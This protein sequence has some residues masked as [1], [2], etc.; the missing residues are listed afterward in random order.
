MSGVVSIT[1][2][3]RTVN[4][5]AL[6]SEG[7]YTQITIAQVQMD[8]ESPLTSVRLVA[9]DDSSAA[10]VSSEN[11]AALTFA[12]NVG[13]ANTYNVILTNQNVGVVVTSTTY[14]LEATTSGTYAPAPHATRISIGSGGGLAVSVRGYNHPEVSTDAMVLDSAT[15][16]VDGVTRVLYPS[17]SAQRKDTNTGITDA[18]RNVLEI[19]VTQGVPFLAGEL[20][21]DAQYIVSVSESTA[22][23]KI[24]A[25]DEPGDLVPPTFSSTAV[26]TYTTRIATLPSVTAGDNDATT[27]TL[28]IL[29]TDRNGDTVARS[30]TVYHLADPTVEVSPV[31]TTLVNSVYTYQSTGTNVTAFTGLVTNRGSSFGSP[32]FSLA[33]NTNFVIT[34]GTSMAI[35]ST[36]ATSD[37]SMLTLAVSGNF[38]AIENDVVFA[39][40][41]I[42]GLLGADTSAIRVWHYDAFEATLSDGA[43][44][45]TTGATVIKYKSVLDTAGTP[46][47]IAS[48]TATGGVGATVVTISGTNAG[49]FAV[50]GSY[51]N[52]ANANSSTDAATSRSITVT[53]TREFSSTSF[54]LTVYF[55]NDPTLVATASTNTGTVKLQD[56]TVN[57]PVYVFVYNANSSTTLFSDIKTAR[58]ATFAGTVTLTAG[59]GLAY[60]SSTLSVNAAAS[61]SSTVPKRVTISGNTSIVE[62]GVTFTTATGVAVDDGGSTTTRASLS[63]YYVDPVTV[64]WY[65]DAGFTSSAGITF[66]GNFATGSVPAPITAFPGT[67]LSSGATVQNVGFYASKRAESTTRLVASGRTLAWAKIVGGV[68]TYNAE[69]FTWFV[70]NVSDASMNSALAAIRAYTS[71]G[72]LVANADVLGD[73]ST[74]AYFIA[75]WYIPNATAGTRTQRALSSSITDA[76][77]GATAQQHVI[78]LAFLSDPSITLSYVPPDDAT[79]GNGYART[80]NDIPFVNLALTNALVSDVTG[81]AGESLALT[82]ADPVVFEIT[83]PLNDSST[84][85]VISFSS[86]VAANTSLTH[87]LYFQSSETTPYL[88]YTENGVIFNAAST[89]S[90]SGYVYLAG[91]GG[92]STPTLT[93]SLSATSV[94]TSALGI[95]YVNIAWNN[96]GTGNK[97]VYVKSSNSSYITF[98]TGATASFTF[99]AGT[100]GS[101]NLLFVAGASSVPTNTSPASAN[102]TITYGFVSPPTT[103]FTSNVITLYA[104]L[105]AASQGVSLGTNSNVVSLQYA[106]V[107]GASTISPITSSDIVFPATGAAA[108]YVSGANVYWSG[109]NGSETLSSLA[110]TNGLTFGAS[111]Q[112]VVITAVSSQVP[113]LSSTTTLSIEDTVGGAGSTASTTFQLASWKPQR[114]IFNGGSALLSVSVGP[115]DVSTT[116]TGGHGALISGS[117]VGGRGAI[118]FHMALLGDDGAETGVNLAGSDFTVSVQSAAGLDNGSGANSAGTVRVTYAGTAAE[119]AGRSYALHVGW[120]SAVEAA[121]AASLANASNIVGW[122]A[123]AA[124]AT[125]LKGAVRVI[126]ATPLSGY[127]FSGGVLTADAN[128][129]LSVD[130]ELLVLNDRV[131]VIGQTVAA[132]NGIYFVSTAGSAS[133]QAVLTRATDANTAGEFVAGNAFVASE[134]ATYAGAVISLSAS[135]TTLDTDAVSFTTESTAMRLNFYGTPTLGLGTSTYIPV[136]LVSTASI[137]GTMTGNVFTLSSTGALSIDGVAVATSDR[138][139][140]RS[141]TTASQNGIYV[142][143][144][145]GDAGVAA[146]L[147]RSSDADAAADFLAGNTVQASAGD[148]LGNTKWR[149]DAG[150][151]TLNSSDITFTAEGTNAYAVAQVFTNKLSVTGGTIPTVNTAY[152]FAHA[153]TEDPDTFMRIYDTAASASI[154]VSGLPTSDAFSLYAVAV[155]DFATDSDAVNA[156]TLPYGAAPADAM[157]LWYTGDTEVGNALPRSAFTLSNGTY[158]ATNVTLRIKSVALDSQRYVIVLVDDATRTCAVGGARL[159]S[160]MARVVLKRTEIITS[161]TIAPV[162]A[163]SWPDCLSLRVTNVG[164][165][166]NGTSPTTTDYAAGSSELAG[167]SLSG[168]LNAQYG[169]SSN[170]TVARVATFASLAVSTL[171]DGVETGSINALMRRLP[172]RVVLAAAPSSDSEVLVADGRLYNAGAI[173]FT[174]E[175]GLAAHYLIE[176]VLTLWNDVAPDFTTGEAAGTDGVASGGTKTLRRAPAF[177]EVRTA[178]LSN[179]STDDDAANYGTVNVQ[180]VGRTIRRVVRDDMLMVHDVALRPFTFTTNYGTVNA[181]DT[182]VY[183]FTAP[184]YSFNLGTASG[185]V[186]EAS[187]GHYNQ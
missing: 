9:T 177:L 27:R 111:S 20:E 134:G 116:S 153:T 30:F 51:V 34:S 54:A 21:G 64:E 94:H 80:E 33:S 141:Q 44:N 56:P 168:F 3:P 163:E 46:L 159:R 138:V 28:T 93:A 72:A 161:V 23:T 90:A 70:S 136:R 133:V 101:E 6:A 105:V 75:E 95:A 29:V 130:G 180:P 47:R 26:D 162:N 11:C 172:E 16:L 117:N 165:T 186:A 148:T 114:E 171:V 68:P 145:A 62:N 118:T 14:T 170:R 67:A 173:G 76:S 81:F 48:G 157:A 61:R 127:S 124:T 98:A 119:L 184:F 154:T 147:T 140:L 149:L 150:I 178:D 156:A 187:P 185:F 55:L 158:T 125:V 151:A 40:T 84:T 83:T 175:T 137:A 69:T 166:L 78:S 155:D 115:W 106:T 91:A 77:N 113:A 132:Q 79:N 41:S 99:T 89:A 32:T 25:V 100:S 86:S 2:V 82:N 182:V 167:L 57:A 108:S 71:G 139:L 45:V 63:A 129:T 39:Q 50:D 176:Y 58:N 5:P 164:T 24:F 110:S 152:V 59:T 4:L 123:R 18:G 103:G 87:T 43:T 65:H 128:G 120:Q 66:N 13:H 112:N 88:T 49:L 12:L 122:S 160:V 142:V 126:Q 17:K 102:S 107:S 131:A 15:P 144:N 97:T 109:G 53:I 92:G 174:H 146:V 52:V 183:G 35:K 38:S 1:N 10:T 143:T 121:T 22:G 60:S 104:D 96:V 31:V 8:S 73:S 169:P 179:V 42:T 85:G 19:R 36:A 37:S 181:A 7:P 74:A 135:V